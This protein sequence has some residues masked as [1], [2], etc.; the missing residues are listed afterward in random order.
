[1]TLT[2]AEFQKQLTE[3]YPKL[4]CKGVDDIAYGHEPG[5]KPESKPESKPE[6]PEPNDKPIYSVIYSVSTAGGDSD[7][8][9]REWKSIFGERSP[10]EVFARFNHQGTS[11]LTLEIEAHQGGRA[12]INLLPRG[13]KNA[14][15]DRI[16][17]YITPN[18]PQP[19]V[20]F[21]RVRTSDTHQGEGRV[22]QHLAAAV[23]LFKEMGI[24]RCLLDTE[25]V[26]GYAWAKFGF[27]PASA[28]EWNDLKSAISERLTDD[29]KTIRFNNK[30]YALTP[31]ETQ[32]IQH[33][34][35]APYAKAPAALP[36]LTELTRTL[37][38]KGKH[39]ITIGK[40]VL[41]DTKWSGILP[42]KDGHPGYERFK[43]YVGKGRAQEMQ[44]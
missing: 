41:L 40:A 5:Q 28:K 24:T 10:K 37:C 6:K 13:N 31:D 17:F 20:R 44:Q 30:P 2:Q 15:S 3:L 27:A 25:K 22:R 4:H 43:T 16:S 12:T 38:N 21:N 26:G 36:A 34:L 1:M 11:I 29:G 35:H 14:I 23:E 9:L 42:L 8:T 33:V 19:Y 18:D 39:T 32:A 7:M